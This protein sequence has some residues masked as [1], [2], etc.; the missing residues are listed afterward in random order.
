M[1][2]AVCTFTLDIFTCD[3]IKENSD[4]MRPFYD[5]LDNLKKLMPLIGM[6]KF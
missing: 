5:R 2:T 6:D 4:K 3:E 1:L